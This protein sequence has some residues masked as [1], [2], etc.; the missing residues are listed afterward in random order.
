MKETKTTHTWRFFRIGGFEQVRLDSAEDIAALRQLDQKLW[1][2]LACPANDLEFDTRTLEMIDADRDGRI[3]APEII[4][5][6]EWVTALLKNPDDLLQGSDTL[7]LSSINEASEE[8]KRLLA[9]AKEI[10][11]NLG[12][13]DATVITLADT[14][15]TAKIFAQTRFNGDGIVPPESAQDE[16]DAELIQDIIKAIGGAVDRNGKQGVSQPHLDEFFSALRAYADWWATGEAAAKEVWPL[17]AGT[18]AAYSAVSAVRIRVDDYFARCRLAAYDPRAT[19]ALNRKEEEYAAQSAR[20]LSADGDEFA[21]FPLAKIQA[22]KPLPLARG[23]NPAW[24]G[25]LALLR[26]AVVEP[27]FGENKTDLTDA[28]WETV[29]AMFASHEQWLSKKGGATVEP[30]GLPRVRELLNGD[31]KERIAALIAKDKAL[32]PEMNAIV[33]VERLIRYHRDLYVLLNNF[34]NFRDFYARVRKSVFQVGTLYLDARACHLCVRVADVA[35]HSVLASQS[36]IYLVYLNCTRRG[37]TEKMTIAAAITD[38][39]ADHLMVGRNGLFY[40]RKGQDWDATIVRIIENPISI[41]QAMWAPYKRIARMLGEQIEKMA[42]AKDKTVSSK[43]A[44]GAQ[45]VSAQAG[46]GKPPAPPAPFDVAKFAGIFAAAGLAVGALGTALAAV[47]TGFLSLGWWQIPLAISGLLLAISAPSVILAW[48][49][50]RR[51]N[52][53]PVLD[54]NGWAVNS[55]VKINIPFGRSLTQLARLP[56]GARF[57]ADPYADK[58][59][60]RWLWVILMLALLVGGYVFYKSQPPAPPAATAPGP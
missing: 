10:L 40:D 7:P 25:R 51:R 32:E 23:C 14:A 44:A 47:I 21:E 13:A 4:A 12:K 27:V 17:G 55:R 19:A 41:R 60:G 36:N 49:K 57:S 24:A 3:R 9:S 15:D 16:K 39:D 43:A 31:E 20:T 5:A 26:E 33:A 52:L 53:G 8:G 48:L 22:E 35:K 30:L 59:R 42:A 2:A 29:K 6:A 46:G 34:V 38:G 28:E 37:S 18:A 58:M 11:T 50:L 1:T 54:A 45:T 56:P